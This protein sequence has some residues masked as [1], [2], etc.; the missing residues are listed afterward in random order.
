MGVV[1]L[2]RDAK[3]IPSIEVYKEKIEELNSHILP[4]DV[5]VGR[6]PFT[7]RGEL[8]GYRYT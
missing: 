5:K 6:Y 8:I 2:R 4:K 3:S 7:E 1:I